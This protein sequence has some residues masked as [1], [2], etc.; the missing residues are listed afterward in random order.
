MRIYAAIIAFITLSLPAPAQGRYFVSG[1][2]AGIA[3]GSRVIITAAELR[4]GKKIAEAPTRKGAFTL[5]GRLQR[6]TY[7]LFNIYTPD[8]I[9]P[10][11]LTKTAEIRFLLDTVPTTI[12]TDTSV[13]FTDSLHYFHESHTAIKGSKWQDE[14][15]EYKKSLSLLEQAKDNA[16]Y[17]E[18]AAWE[19]SNG[20]ESAILRYKAVTEKADSALLKAKMDFLHRHPD[21][22][23]SAYIAEGRFFEFFKYTEKELNELFDIVKNNP[24]T[25]RINFIKNNFGNFKRYVK[26]V[27]YTDFIGIDANGTEHKLSQMIKPGTVTL[28]DF[29]GSWDSPSK[30][31]LPQITKLTGEFKNDLTAIG[32][33]IDETDNDW[34]KEIRM[35]Q[36]PWQQVIIPKMEFANKTG[37]AYYIQTI[38]TLVIIDQEGRIT[39]TTHEPAKARAEITALINR[40]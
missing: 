34:K 18:A 2:I 20:R 33:A 6:P 12:S 13:I 37:Q 3:D 21:Y 30:Q 14:Y 19:R 8:K 35:A 24:D 28:V 39:M 25:A 1:N 7:C 27:K 38:P 26:G 32:A 40:R 4:N 10:N 16:E 17:A 36:L 22:A 23:I 5:T 29:W 31:I 9:V 15:T 11:R